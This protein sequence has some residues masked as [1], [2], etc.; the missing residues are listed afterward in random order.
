[1]VIVDNLDE[2]LELGSLLLARLGHASGDLGGVALD[3]GND[4][5]AEGVRHVAIVDGLD[6]DDLLFFCICQRLYSFNCLSTRNNVQGA[7][8]ANAGFCSVGGAW[9]PLISLD[10][11]FNAF[12]VSPCQSSFLLIVG[13]FVVVVRD[14][15]HC[16]TCRTHTK[17]LQCCLRIV[18]SCR[19]IGRG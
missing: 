8:L 2:G 13:C 15:G 19:H 7:V 3:A 5:V 17:T 16:C 14:D 4:G 9:R 6:D 1:V 18:P 10:G 11:T 12:V